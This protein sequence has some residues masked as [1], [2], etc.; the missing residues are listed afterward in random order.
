MA[1]NGQPLCLPYDPNAWSWLYLYTFSIWVFLAVWL[2]QSTWRC[3]CVP[4]KLSLIGWWMRLQR[5]LRHCLG[6]HSTHPSWVR[7]EQSHL[8]DQIL[9]VFVKACFFQKLVFTYFLVN[10]KY[11]NFSGGPYVLYN[12]SSKELSGV[13]I[14]PYCT[15]DQSHPRCRSLPDSVTYSAW[16]SVPQYHDTCLGVRIQGN[17]GGSTLYSDLF[18]VSTTQ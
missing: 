6:G 12:H 15:K 8:P 11:K 5:N 17:Y 18:H 3:G 14:S 7:S 4:I 1:G 9:F 13:L 16:Y 10:Q 2:T